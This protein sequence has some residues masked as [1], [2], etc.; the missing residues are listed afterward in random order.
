MRPEKA[1]GHQRQ[2]VAALMALILLCVRGSK[3]TKQ[4]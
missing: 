2:M 1:R 4:L 3:N